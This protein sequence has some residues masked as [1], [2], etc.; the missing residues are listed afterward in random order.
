MDSTAT[1][2][3]GEADT[4]P[5]ILV[6]DD[7]PRALST[8][9]EH[10]SPGRFRIVACPFGE[11]AFEAIAAGK[12]HLVLVNADRFYLDGNGLQAQVHAMSAETRVIYLDEDG[13]WL[14]FIEPSNDGGTDLLVNPCTSDRIAEVIDELLAA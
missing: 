13:D 10:V 1:P 5:F 8:L 6:A 7:R 11:P 3:G 9:S 2:A 4:L 12:P 14:L